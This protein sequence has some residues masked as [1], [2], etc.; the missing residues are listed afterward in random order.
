MPKMSIQICVRLVKRPRTTS[1]LHV[2]VAQQRVA[3]A[4]QEH[5]REQVP[6][7]LQ[8]GVRADVE[9]LADDRVDGADQ[10]RGQHQP[11]HPAADELVQPVDRPGQLQQCGHT[12]LREVESERS[13]AACDRAAREAPPILRR[14]ATCRVNAGVSGRARPRACGDGRR[15]P[16]PAPRARAAPTRARCG[17]RPGAARQLR[18]QLRRRRR[19]LRRLVAAVR[20]AGS[21]TRGR[22]RGPRPRS[23]RWSAG[24]GRPRSRGGC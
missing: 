10:H 23:R 7:D 15:Q 2:L 13:A 17:R 11:G 5:G 8:E 16:P 21:G 6:L 20:P 18:E 22:R 9:R 14:R 4:E 3:G 12:A 24:R 19:S 1:I